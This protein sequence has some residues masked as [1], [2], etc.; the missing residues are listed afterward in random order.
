M[1]TKGSGMT[2]AID[3]YKGRCKTGWSIRQDRLTGKWEAYNRAWFDGPP[4]QF[5]T[6]RR[7]AAYVEASTYGRHDRACTEN[8]SA[9][10]DFYKL[11]PPIKARPK[12]RPGMNRWDA[13]WLLIPQR[14]V[15]GLG[16]G[17]D[18]TI[19]LAEFDPDEKGAR[20]SLTNTGWCGAMGLPE[21]MLR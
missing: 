17:D 2:W 11:I 8:Y 3:T 16:Q 6:F 13:S 9:L 14:Y 7:A 12:H 18:F 1:A 19:A 4:V 5:A 21:E 15:V 20:W 10:R